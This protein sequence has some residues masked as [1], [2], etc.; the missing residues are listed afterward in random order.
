MSVF[1]D[2]ITGRLC[3]FKQRFVLKKQRI[4]GFD[5]VICEGVDFLLRDCRIITSG[6]HSLAIGI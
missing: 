1:A 2:Q 3:V 6:K 4:P 5:G